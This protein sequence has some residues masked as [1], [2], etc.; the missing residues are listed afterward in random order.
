VNLLA[1]TMTLAKQAGG[2]D[3]LTRLVS[4]LEE[5]QGK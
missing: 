1:A 4:V 3:Q 5:L 2:L